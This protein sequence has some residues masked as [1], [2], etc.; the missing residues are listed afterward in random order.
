M[1][2]FRTLMH[3]TNKNNNMNY[4]TLLLASTL[5]LLT[6]CG[7]DS[8]SPAPIYNDEGEDIELSADRIAKSRLALGFNHSCFIT[9]DNGSVKCWGANHLGQLGNGNKTKEEIEEELL[10]RKNNGENITIEEINAEQN[11]LTS[12]IPVKV[13]DSNDVITN[14]IEISAGENHTCALLQAGNVKCWGDNKNNLLGDQNLE[15]PASSVAVEVTDLQNVKSISAGNTYN[16]ALLEAGDIK[17]WGRRPNSFSTESLLEI[18]HN[19]PTQ[20]ATASSHICGVVEGNLVQCRGDNSL[21]QLGYSQ[22]EATTVTG[23]DNA[24]LVSN[25]GSHSCALLN[26]GRVKCWGTN[27]YGEIGNGQGTHVSVTTPNQVR[28]LSKVKS[29]SSG[30]RYNCAA[31]TEGQALCWGNNL[32]G[33]L[34]YVPSKGATH[35]RPFSSIPT[36]V[37]GITTANEV[38]VSQNHSCA[39]LI[40]EA[41]EES[42]SCWGKNDFGQLG[43][44]KKS[45]SDE[46][47]TPQSISSVPVKVKF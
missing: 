28:N 5:L 11:K 15:K 42:V 24:L 18:T 33:Q 43:N 29:L 12:S 6:A 31:T 3:T 9:A 46:K 19:S 7:G 1:L 40:S 13:K 8:S 10:D 23:I 27:Q 37:E 26:N 16:C 30:V 20:L 17:C 21:G 25:I 36:V 47:K 34:G 4:L 22:T 39:L 14:A 41:K 35:V 32:Y 2:Y 38:S 44:G 45:T